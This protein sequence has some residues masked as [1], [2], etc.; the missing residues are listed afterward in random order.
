[1]PTR[2]VLPGIVL[3]MGL[4]GLHAGHAQ[5]EA[6]PRAG[7]RTYLLTCPA[8]DAR[9]DI[10]AVDRAQVEKQLFVDVAGVRLWVADPDTLGRIRARI[11][12]PATAYRLVLASVTEKLRETG[13]E[14]DP[15][16]VRGEEGKKLGTEGM[17]LIEGGEFTRPGEY[18]DSSGGGLTILPD[19]SVK[20]SRG[21]KYRVRVSSFYIDK[22][23]VTNED[24]C[25]FLNDGNAGYWTPWN[26]CI[27][28]STTGWP[29]PA[30]K[31][32]P[33]ARAI[34][35]HHVAS[36]NWYQAKGYAAWA[37][38]QLPTEA[39]WEFA[40]GG[41]HGFKYPWGNE[42]P[43]ETRANFPVKFRHTLP[44]DMY[45]AGATPEGVLQ[46]AGN[47]AEWCADYFDYPSYVKAPL[48]GVLVDP[49][50]PEQG[51]RPNE[52]FKFNV[53]M[54][55]WCKPGKEEHL[56]GT[57]RHGRHPLVE[58]PEGISIRCVKEAR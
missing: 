29:A 4:A 30:G 42:P 17:V 18:Y 10:Q 33:A 8:G 47:A 39:E 41:K 21:E 14:P 50:G 49:K 22:F 25:K 40:A 52:W 9:V 56:T 15:V 46:M 19:G 27:V 53:A 7:G 58:D 5:D 54:K 36:V 3:A 16:P 2:T 23:K 55:G 6:V 34:A 45:P 26:P 24:Y 57:K 32:V 31:F 1:M 51:F 28:R 44:V 12:D 20:V 37:G 35:K 11:A 43:D 38:K 13:I 48:G